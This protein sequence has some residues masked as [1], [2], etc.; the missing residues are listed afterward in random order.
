[1]PCRADAG[2]L[3]LISRDGTTADVARA[4]AHPPSAADVGDAVGEGS[5]F[6]CRRARRAG[7]HRIA[8]GARSRNIPTAPA[9]AP[10]S[11]KPR[12]TCRC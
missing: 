12:W 1:M 10:I 5:D 3:L 2:M 4:V 8:R 11:S 7:D 6:R 9:T